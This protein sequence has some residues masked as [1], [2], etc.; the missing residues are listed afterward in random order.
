MVSGVA[1]VLAGAANTLNVCVP[2]L[3]SGAVSAVFAVPSRVMESTY[4][5]RSWPGPLP[6]SSFRKV[7]PTVCVPGPPKCPVKVNAS[8]CPRLCDA[9]TDCAAPSGTPSM[10]T[11]NCASPR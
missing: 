2:L 3:Y 5:L 9:V 7:T 4:R 10:L 1:W 11:V 6:P 8:D